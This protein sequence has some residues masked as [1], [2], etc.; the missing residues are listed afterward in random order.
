MFGNK[1]DP[2]GMKYIGYLAENGYDYIEL[3]LAQIMALPQQEFELLQKT[4]EKHKI[5]CECC[6]NFFPS[7]IRL[8]GDKVN[9]EVIENYIRDACNRA[10]AL[11]AKIIVFGSSAAKNVPEGFSKETAFR[12]IVKVLKISDQYIAHKGMQIAIEPLNREESNIIL[13]LSDGKKLMQAAEVS[14][15]KLLVD[16]YHFTLEKEN[17]NHITENGKDI[18]HVHFAE[19]QGR[20]FPIRISEDYINFFTVLKKTGYH[21]RISFEAYARHG[22]EDIKNAIILLRKCV[23]NL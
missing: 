14:G 20:L 18:I 13:N 8:T 4:L 23:E 11:G 10:G 3:P 7:W 1:E 19:P 22:K 16:Y 5:S 21:S 6:N 17:L 2:I 12:Q 15:V 9:A